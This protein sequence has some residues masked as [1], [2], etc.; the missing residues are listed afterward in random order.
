MLEATMKRSLFTALVLPFVVGVM[1]QFSPGALAQGRGKWTT[2]FDGKSL[3]G[4][5][6]IGNANWR[7]VGGYV[8]ADQG[9][10]YLVTDVSYSDFQLRVEFWD[11]GDTNSG[12]FL[13]CSNP[14]QVSP[15][16]CYEANIWD[17][18]TVDNYRTG[19]IVDLAKPAGVVNTLDKWNTYEISAQGMHLVVTLNGVR[20]VDI[21]NDKYA[22]GP[23]A[24]QYAAVRDAKGIVRFRKVEIRTP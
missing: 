23:I 14:Q 18:R 16:T 5:N 21:N 24:L 22:R 15:A 12:V 10:G 7:L 8:Q 6:Q 13:R 4:W 20:T 17:S 3:K 19:G 2:L 1:L 11:T 9:T